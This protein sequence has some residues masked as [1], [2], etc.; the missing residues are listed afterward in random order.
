MVIQSMAANTTISVYK[1]SICII[2]NINTN[3]YY[4]IF[5]FFL[6]KFYIVNNLKTVVGRGFFWVR[7]G[8]GV[9]ARGV[10]LGGFEQH[11]SRDWQLNRTIF[12]FFAHSLIGNNQTS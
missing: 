11:Y 10:S 9:S 6:L 2:I 1:I 5:Y 3:F 7:L 8:H 12:P 4:S